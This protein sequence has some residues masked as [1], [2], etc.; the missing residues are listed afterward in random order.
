MAVGLAFE[1]DRKDSFFDSSQR[2]RSLGIAADEGRLG[3]AVTRSPMAGGGQGNGSTVISYGQHKTAATLAY[4]TWAWPERAVQVT[5]VM[6][7][8]CKI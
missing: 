3:G 5:S 8:F 4:V 1:N 7:T 6:A 2:E